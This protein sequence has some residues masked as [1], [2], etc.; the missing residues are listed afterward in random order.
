MRGSPGSGRTM[1]AQ[2]TPVSAAARRTAGQLAEVLGAPA[3]NAA[4]RVQQVVTTPGV[5]LGRAAREQMEGRF[6]S[7]FTR[8]RVHADAAA[9]SSAD[10]LGAR[11]YAFGEHIVL[12]R[13]AQAG[14]AMHAQ[15]LSHELAHV[16]QQRR[17][18]VHP[19]L[20][21]GDAVEP[22]AQAAAQQFD[23]SEGTLRVAG[24]SAIGLACDGE[25]DSWTARL[26]RKAAA[27]AA[28][29]PPQYRQTV[30]AAAEELK[31][32]ARDKV[33]QG[34]GTVKGVATQVTEVADTALWVGAEYQQVRDAVAA[35][36]AGPE[37]SASNRAV[38][39]ALDSGMMLLPGGQAIP[40]LAKASQMAKEHGLVDSQTG[41]ASVTAPMADKLN[42]LA[43]RAETGLGA[44]PRDP[45]MFSPMEV[46]ELEASIG[47]QVALSFTGAEEVKVAMNVVGA[48][49]GLRGVVTSIERDPGWA[50]SSQ[51]WGSVIGMVLSIVGLKHS[52]AAGK[53]TT[54]L[55]KYGWV[56]AAVPPLAQLAA[57]YLQLETHPDMEAGQ[58][59]QLEE[60]IK[61][62]WKAA[63]NVLK[64]AILHVA[65]SSGGRD[66]APA[67]GAPGEEGGNVVKPAAAA[68]P[69][70]AAKPGAPPAAA[71]A[72]VVET[73]V[74][75]PPVAAPA[76]AP[77]AA[78]A[79]VKAAPT[80]GKLLPLERAQ[81][82]ARSA[83]SR[84]LDAHLERLPEQQRGSVTSLRPDTAPA[85]APPPLR[86]VQAA[87]MAVGQ[88]HGPET[89]GNA[90]PMLQLI[91]GGAEPQAPGRASGALGG[92]VAQASAGKGTG[93][94]SMPDRR[95]AV[96]GSG[97]APGREGASGVGPRGAAAARKAGRPADARTPSLEDRIEALSA[98]PAA[99][100]F[101]DEFQAIQKLRASAHDPA[102][103]EQRM[104]A[105]HS[106]VDTA[107]S[108]ASAGVLNKPRT[109]SLQDD[110]S[111]GIEGTHAIG[112]ST[113]NRTSRT[114]HEGVLG[115]GME[116]EGGAIPLD[117]DRH[118]VAPKSGGGA[119]GE[120]IRE[121]LRIAGVSID[122]PASGAPLA[123]NPR[124]PRAIHESDMAHSRAHTSRLPESN[125]RLL[126]Q[127]LRAVHGDADGVRAVLRKHAHDLYEG[128]A[129]TAQEF[130]LGPDFEA[131]DD[132]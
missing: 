74:S 122:D 37:G 15:V 79:P 19:A 25:D 86:E 112:T 48:V 20:Q 7:D 47:T 18:G 118:H 87:R 6:A 34:L 17:G 59:K 1:P 67:R 31:G 66:A 116:R 50:T 76:A 61:Q 115:R 39:T 46:A 124:D 126:L 8:V 56:A 51:F 130:R 75:A 105:L 92:D 3:R 129:R 97:A 95:P 107:E 13:A 128:R 40:A 33:E 16:V 98:H 113:R 83:A 125:W 70:A 10:A 111:T 22:G 101:Q 65:Q 55:L 73:P 94:A 29:V 36:V 127:D 42:E 123:G 88:T 106:A 62:G 108:Q 30:Q 131:D 96:S 100:R 43:K 104:R 41:D 132:E 12:G 60:R 91:K 71:P 102:T 77:Q 14:G 45:E 69:D 117:H 21:P 9:Q 109:A 63:V 2:A 35:K 114:S 64:D 5:P 54:L 32:Y 81:P 90:P 23:A 49:G 44:K 121:E 58:R 85:G 103:V 57:D 93:G 27:M 72:P 78:V 11:A 38:R 68:K 80:R 120:A 28:V 99:E 82:P 53:I 52:M 4:D 89:V 26:R 24:A 84:A 110:G 119:V